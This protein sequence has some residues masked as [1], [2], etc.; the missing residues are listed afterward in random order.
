MTSMT[1][2]LLIRAG[3]D[4][5]QLRRMKGRTVLYIAILFLTGISLSFGALAIGNLVG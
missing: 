2:S 5:H 4:P 3:V 1:D